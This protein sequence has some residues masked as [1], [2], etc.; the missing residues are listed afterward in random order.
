M[1]P[2]KASHHGGRGGTQSR[3]WIVFYSKYLSQRFVEL[4][5]NDHEH[6][7]LLIGVLPMT[8]DPVCGMKVDETNAKAQTTYH[9]QKYSFCSDECRQKFEQNPEQYAQSAAA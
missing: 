8:K 3:F 2:E 7:T 1:E 4:D 6:A 5:D 9:G